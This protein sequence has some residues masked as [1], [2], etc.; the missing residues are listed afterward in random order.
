MM[1][2][3]R[4]N[5]LRAVATRLNQE[6]AD[7]AN[8]RMEITIAGCYLQR[9]FAVCVTCLMG[10]VMMVAVVMVVVVVMMTVTMRIMDMR[11][12][13]VRVMRDDQPVLV[14]LIQRQPMQRV[15]K[16]RNGAVSCQQRA[17]QE[18]LVD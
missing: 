4:R 9:L 11:R 12:A 1:P 16:Q 2:D 7:I 5:N 10:V 13:T 3:D 17:S 14:P 15:A 18:F 6:R 8:V